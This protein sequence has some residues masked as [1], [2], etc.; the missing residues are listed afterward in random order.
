MFMVYPEPPSSGLRWKHEA[1]LMML[2]TKVGTG[3]RIIYL[4]QE[5][6][7]I[8]AFSAFRDELYNMSG[9]AINTI[10]LYLGHIARFIEFIHAC[11]ILQDKY[12][13]S[14]D[15]LIV[16]FEAYMIGTYES[17]PTIALLARRLTGRTSNA[18]AHSMVT[19][20][21]A[22]TRFLWFTNISADTSLGLTHYIDTI[23]R[24]S[25][26]STTELRGFRN[27]AEAY[28]LYTEEHKTNRIMKMKMRHKRLFRCTKN[29]PE[30]HDELE[31]RNE[32]A[33]PVDKCGAMEDALRTHRDR[34]LFYLRIA[35]GMRTSEALGLTDADLD[36]LEREIWIRADITRKAALLTQDQ[37]DKYSF[38]GRSTPETMGHEPWASKFW[39]HYE[40]YIKY[41]RMPCVGH[42]FCF[43]ILHG[44]NKGAP[45]FTANRSS[46]NRTFHRAA[47]IA[48]VS[49][50]KGVAEHSLRHRYGVH[51]RHYAP[52]LF[53]N[54]F[55]EHVTQAYMGQKSTKSTRKY[56]YK[57]HREWLDT[58][59][60]IIDSKKPD[61][62]KS[63]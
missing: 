19:V 62:E 33:F 46:L 59:N 3:R 51:T 41:E 37:I 21:A 57:N 28:G 22:I 10:K 24:T 61:L 60:A 31:W 16:R 40:L 23:S 45:L 50:F 34:A 48:G 14:I 13:I 52:T 39:E 20:E 54:G 4:N 36:V 38:K 11:M 44:K 47:S 12:S 58:A 1:K 15:Y 32:K 25:P 7:E 53:G 49:L 26:L 29:I 17:Q 56:T 9:L 18:K 6:E 43:Q 8:A 30:N 42:S 27:N 2:L 63:K 35:Y 55:P 5:G